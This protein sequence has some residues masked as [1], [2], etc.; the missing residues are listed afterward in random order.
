MLRPE[1]Y[2]YVGI[3]PYRG[4]FAVKTRDFYKK[5]QQMQK[6]RMESTWLYKP[7]RF[8]VEITNECN[9]KCE[10]CGMNAVQSGA[11]IILSDEL[12]HQIPI[13][14][15]QVGIPSISITGGEPFLYFSKLC[16]LIQECTK[17]AVDI[18]KIT[19]NGYWGEKPEE[20]FKKLK[21]AGFFKNKYFVPL[22]MFSIGEN[23]VPF[24][25]IA[26]I[27]KYVDTNFSPQEV[28]LCVSSMKE[29]GKNSLI[30]QFINTYEQLFGTFPEDRI[31]LTERVY[32]N[33][34]YNPT[35]AIRVE[36]DIRSYA[37]DCYMCFWPTVGAYVLPTLFMKASGDC[38][39]CAAFNVPDELYFGNIHNMS[40]WQILSEA[41]NNRYVRLIAENGL[42]GFY[43]FIDK[44]VLEE[45]TAN[46]YCDA[47]KKLI[48]L[49][50]EKLDLAK[51]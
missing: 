11:G 24:E 15:H 27:F 48:A 7:L 19:T 34:K 51:I 37:N 46:D 22:I 38:Y 21:N 2:K 30:D 26:N 4:K 6:D 12:M 23:S 32:L 49:S 10:H 47:C 35:K 36:M 13:E 45:T 33:S 44:N 8:E 50:K 18:C 28:N 9:I 25:T 16:D 29:K 31:Y 20:Y 42:K 1:D 14:L 43:K 3:I 39:S 41:N 40:I 17:S 5:I